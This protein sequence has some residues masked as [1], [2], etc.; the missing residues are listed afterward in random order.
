[1]SQE[2]SPPLLGPSKFTSEVQV[3]A[4]SP[5]QPV[6]CSADEIVDGYHEEEVINTET[7]SKTLTRRERTK[8]IKALKTTKGADQCRHSTRSSQWI[9]DE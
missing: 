8:K 4:T 9:L 1:L 3:R 5:I 2:I 7:P 6:E